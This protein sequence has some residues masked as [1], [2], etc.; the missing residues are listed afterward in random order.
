MAEPSETTWHFNLNDSDVGSSLT[1]RDG[2]VTRILAG[3]N[4]MFSLVTIHPNTPT[5]NHSHPEEQWGI[6]LE[7]SCTR[8]QNGQEVEMTPGDIWY[9]PANADHGI[10]TGALYAKILDV[11]SPPRPSYLPNEIAPT[12]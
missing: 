2:V 11:F 9:T 10:R 12:F 6:L 4:V 1:L 8:I 7:G 5:K 3:K